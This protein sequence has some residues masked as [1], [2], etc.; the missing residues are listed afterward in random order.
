MPAQATIPAKLS[1]TIDEESK[2]F[3]DKIKFTQYFSTTPAP[4]R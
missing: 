4:K 3:H 2:I 1:I